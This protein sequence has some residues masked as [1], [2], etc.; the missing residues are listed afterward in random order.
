[1][2]IFLSLCCF[3][4]FYLISHSALFH[5]ISF[6]FYSASPPCFFFITSGILNIFKQFPHECLEK[7]MRSSLHSCLRVIL[8][9]KCHECSPLSWMGCRLEIPIRWMSLRFVVRPPGRDNTFTRNQ[10][11]TPTITTDLLGIF[12]RPIA[13]VCELFTVCENSCG[14]SFTSLNSGTSGS[15]TNWD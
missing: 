3:S 10:L 14:G 1:M 6:I 9:S 15:V 8:R 2:G 12:I 13:T 11:C 5:F 4:S 7:A